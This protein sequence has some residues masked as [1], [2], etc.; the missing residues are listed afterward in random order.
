MYT[1]TLLP[2]LLLLSSPSLIHA[3]P[4]P[5]PQ[6][7]PQFGIHTLESYLDFN[8]DV[9][10]SQIAAN[11]LSQSLLQRKSQVSQPQSQSQSQPESHKFPQLQLPPQPQIQPQP[12]VL[13]SFPGVGVRVPVGGGGS[14]MT[15]HGNIP[16]DAA[17]ADFDA[18]M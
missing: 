3:I 14:K 11:S 10:I 7:H 5:E 16:G 1:S 8:R 2:L 6:P 13:S 17:R 12:N 15:T 18:R 4:I 9:S